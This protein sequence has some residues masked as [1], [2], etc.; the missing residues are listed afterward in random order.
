MPDTETATTPPPGAPGASQAPLQPGAGGVEFDLMS[1]ISRWGIYRY[2]VGARQDLHGD[3]VLA[4]KNSYIRADKDGYV[5]AGLLWTPGSAIFYNNGKEIF[6]WE[7]ARVGDAQV[8]LRY[9]MVIGGP[10]NDHIDDAK[11]P[12]DFSIDYVRAWQ[13]KDLAGS[14]DGSKTNAGDPNESKN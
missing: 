6:R 11:L 13:R 7:D 4:T 8:C 1:L 10:D 3:K 14:G 12:A 5:T 2:S 9:D